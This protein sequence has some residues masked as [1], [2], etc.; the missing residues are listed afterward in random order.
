MLPADLL[1]AHHVPDSVTGQ[2][3]ELVPLRLPV[4]IVYRSPCVKCVQK[5]LCQVCTEVP[6]FSGYMS[7]C[8]KCVQK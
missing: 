5:S 6:V 7:P 1:I 2:H 8:V 3:Q 4:L